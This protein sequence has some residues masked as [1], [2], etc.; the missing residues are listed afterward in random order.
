MEEIALIYSNHCQTVTKDGETVK[1]EIYSSGK[2]DWIVEVVD[3]YGNST[4]WDRPIAGARPIAPARAQ[5]AAVFEMGD[6]SA[7]TV[8][9]HRKPYCVS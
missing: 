6:A 9:L 4:V 5:K 2:D 1:V 8:A 3:E 7:A